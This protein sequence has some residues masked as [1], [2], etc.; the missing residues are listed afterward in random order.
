MSSRLALEDVS[1]QEVI[2]SIPRRSTSLRSALAASSCLIEDHSRHTSF[3]KSFTS[4]EVAQPARVCSHSPSFSDSWRSQPASCSSSLATCSANPLAFCSESA[5]LASTFWA[6]APWHEVASCSRPA[7]LPSSAVLCARTWFS[8]S[9]EHF[10][11]WSASTSWPSRSHC[12]GRPRAASTAGTSGS[13]ASSLASYSSRRRLARVSSDVAC[14]QRATA[15]RCLLWMAPHS[16]LRPVLLRWLAQVCS[17][18]KLRRSFDT[19]SLRFSSWTVATI[20]V[21]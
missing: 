17:L 4:V 2:F 13:R 1:L 5:R 21:T 7:C 9:L 20:W 14:D 15:C 11:R 3:S 6:R 8:S 16:R 12:A 10:S 19:A 18:H